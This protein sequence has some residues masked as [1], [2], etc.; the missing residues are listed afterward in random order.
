MIVSY[1]D[2]DMREKLST[3]IVCSFVV[4]SNVFLIFIC[5]RREIGNSGVLIAAFLLS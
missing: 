4:S 2:I 3:I 5:F 1:I